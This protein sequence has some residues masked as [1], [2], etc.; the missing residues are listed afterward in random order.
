MMNSPVSYI[1]NNPIRDQ[2]EEWRFRG[3][4]ASLQ[5]DEIEVENDGSKPFD[6]DL[7]PIL[8]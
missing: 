4:A 2:L 6:E 7:E 3:Y 5:N 8:I 1:G